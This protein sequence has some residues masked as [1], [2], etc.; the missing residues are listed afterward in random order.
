MIRAILMLNPQ[1]SVNADNSRPLTIQNIQM[2]CNDV[3]EGT[4]NWLETTVTVALEK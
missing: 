4:L 1:L 2:D 3:E